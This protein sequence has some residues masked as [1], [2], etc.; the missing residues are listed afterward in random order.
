MKSKRLILCSLLAILF[1]M[2]ACSEHCNGFPNE[3]T[4]Y[5]PYSQ[6]QIINFVNEHND[7]LSVQVA[8]NWKTK[9]YEIK[10]GC[11]CICEAF[12]EFNFSVIGN[13]MFGY[14]SINC[15]MDATR[16]LYDGLLSFY[17][18]FYPI[19]NID[20]YTMEL[21]DTINGVNQ[22]GDISNIEIIRGKGITSFSD[23]NL[24]CT[25]KLSEN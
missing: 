4:D 18:S 21:T 8:D 17:I 2:F 20:I 10:L 6:G 1:A 19:N 7:T 25:W 22:S 11:K 13:Y 5:L 9:P 12:Y 3:L 16:I 24:N 14:Q 15:F 23:K